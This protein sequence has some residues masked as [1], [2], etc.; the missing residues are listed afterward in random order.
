[1]DN[2]LS[3]KEI[4]GLKVGSMNC[5]GLGDKTKLSKVLTWLSKKTEDIIFLQETHSTLESEVKWKKTWEGGIYFSHGASNSTGVAILI[6]KNEDIKV[7][8]IRTI[9]QGRVLLMEITYNTIKYCLVNNY[10]PNNDDKQFIENVFLETLGRSR[11]DHLIMA[12]DWN[13]VLNNNLDKLGGAAQHANKNYQSYINNMMS[14]YGLCDIFRLSRGDERV[15]THFNKTFKTASRL[16]FFLIDDN[17][18]NFP[19]C[20]TN[21]SHGYNTDHSYIS[22]NIQGSSIE[23]G[24]GYWKLNNSHLRDEDFVNEVKVIIDDT[25]NSNF[26]S[27]AGLWDVIKIKI[28]DFAI[29]YGKKKKKENQEEKQKLLKVIEDIKSVP[30]FIENDMTRKELFEAEVKLNC[31]IDSEIKGA[32]TRSRAQWTEEGER[33]TKYFFGLEKSNYKKK[34]LGKLVN[35]GKELY[36]QRDISNHV[37]DFY[38]KLFRSTDPDKTNMSDYIASSRTPTVDSNLAEDLDS[39]I[40]IGEIDAVYN[41]LKNNKSPGWDGLTAEFYKTF[42][43]DIRTILF[44]CYLESI[45]NSSLSPSQRIGVLTLIPKPKPPSELVYIKNWRPITLLNVDYKIFTHVIKNRI[46]R[47]L[48]DI[49]SN[50]QSGFQAG[51]STCDNLILMYLTLEHFDN[52]PEKEGLLL[53]VDFEKAFDTVEHEFLYKTLETMGFGKYL[54]KLVKVAF[55]GC[56]NYANVNGYLTSPIYISRGLHQGSP[57]SPILFLIVAQI[58]TKKLE[59]RS[60]II[61]LEISG[62]NIL[63]S[64]FADDTDLFLNASIDCLAA[65]IE[66]LIAF[67]THSGCK[68]NV[69]KTTCIPLGKAKY[70]ANLLGQISCKNY[71]PDF[72]QDTFTA[73]GI[74]FSNNTS[75]VGIM[76]VNYEAKITKAKS[77]VN[78]WSRRDLTLMGKVT[79]IKSLIYSQFSY[80]A[81]PLIKPSCP[82]MKRI[83]TLTFNFLWGGKRDKVK[84][85]VIKRGF[86]EGG[87]GLFDF[88]EFLTSL[89]LTLIKKIINPNFTHNWKRVFIKQLKFPDKIEIS[90]ENALTRDN[91]KITKDILMCYTEWKTKVANARG[92]CINHIVWANKEITDIGSQMWNETLISRGIKYISDFL[93]PGNS[94]MTYDQ[95]RENWNLSISEISRKQYVDVK[96]AIRRFNCPTIASRDISQVDRAAC[97]SFFFNDNGSIKI[98]IN[99]KIIRNEMY[100]PIS[101]NLLPALKEWSRELD[102]NDI[103]WCQVLNNLFTGITNNYKLIQFQYKLLM[104]ISTCKYMRYKMQ[105]AKDSDQCSLCNSALETL[106]HIFLYCPYS[107]AFTDKLN[108]FIRDNIYRDFR[109]TKK[110]YLITSNHANPIVNYFNITAKWYISKKFQN[111]KP[112]IWDEYIRYIRVALTGEKQYIRV[113]VDDILA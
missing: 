75:V 25:I 44:N 98:S 38:K 24:K 85:E 62:V 94:V 40:Y 51:K 14:D 3:S 72:I 88:S 42:W 81:I 108:T 4:A 57:L 105:I 33:S 89:K 45:N 47:S 17:L 52:H 5:N 27:Y 1:M 111:A 43:D 76:E 34:S 46:L 20:D 56:M 9:C 96:M 107:I 12:G 87:L 23:K 106:A 67:G 35:N 29:R 69:E 55:H 37:V 49:I 70:N 68:C 15:Y 53:Q 63:L 16:D 73:L 39:E 21:I 18:S 99:G 7:D 66:E 11:D 101:P 78:V 113:T 13:T 82:M 28:K 79:I 100:N 86:N 48:P 30:N 59:N 83:D 112:L 41:K 90:I 65:V 71:G 97:L 26:D 6:R 19:I 32:I 36:N 104:R 8:N 31:I 50:A 95:F 54:I 22:L 2:S 58:F 60:D 77:W 64:L 74:N 61:G 102:K 80:L 93:A 110:Y 103:D 91:C 10:S 109:D 84:R 92:E